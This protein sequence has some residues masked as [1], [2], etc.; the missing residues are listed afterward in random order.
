MAPNGTEF[1]FVV[2]PDPTPS[3]RVALSD[4]SEAQ[5]RARVVELRLAHELGH[6]FFYGHDGR[7][8]LPA[9]PAEEEFCDAFAEAYTGLDA[10]AS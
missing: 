9:S 1:T 7:R 2:D 8:L 3:E 6:V 10:V 4:L 5:K